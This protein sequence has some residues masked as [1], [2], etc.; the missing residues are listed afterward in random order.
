MKKAWNWKCPYPEPRLPDR[1]GP[2]QSY[3][4]CRSSRSQQRSSWFPHYKAPLWRQKELW[5]HAEMSV[6]KSEGNDAQNRGNNM[7]PFSLQSHTHP[8]SGH[9]RSVLAT[10][11]S[12]SWDRLINIMAKPR[13][14]SCGWTDRETITTWGQHHQLSS[15]A[16]VA[17]P[18]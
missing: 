6:Q 13:R 11:S 4:R 2:P 18:W 5:T 15:P 10:S 3:S 1:P 14:A 9:L 17:A 12:F 7:Q 16:N 8:S